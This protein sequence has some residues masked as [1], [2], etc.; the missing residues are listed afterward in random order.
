MI[1]GKIFSGIISSLN[2]HESISK[3]RVV[4]GSTGILF[5]TSMHVGVTHPFKEF[6][7]L[8]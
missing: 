5:V 8:E 7:I 3:Q 4:P 1:L 2:E 6:I